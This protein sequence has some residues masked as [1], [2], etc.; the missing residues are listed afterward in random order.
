[1][2]SC[3]D[4]LMQ[5]SYRIG[6]S[7]FYY[8]QRLYGFG[9][10]TNVDLPGEARTDSLLFSEEDLSKTVNMATNSFGQNFN[11]TMIQLAS[12]FSSLVNGGNFYQP[13]VVT[14]IEDESG[15]VLQEINPV[16]EKVTFSEEVSTQVK[17]Y[18]RQVVESGTG[19]T[20]GV[21][22]YDLGG[23]TGTAQKIPRGDGNYLVSF[24]GYAPQDDP[25]VL[26]YCVVD[27]PNVTDQAHSVYAQQ[28][29]HN[30]LVQ[31]LPYLN[32]ETIEEPEGSTATAEL[33]PY[34]Q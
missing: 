3:N 32:I 18:L 19:K 6:G 2:D 25:E 34:G 31:I 15:N 26:I 13:H 21:A 1:M 30:I 22:G 5:I 20:A 7:N 14:R 4:A 12:A 28:I 29:V 9:Q 17:S 23:K 33:I 27:Q 16:V 10:K 24:I 11:T 8:Y